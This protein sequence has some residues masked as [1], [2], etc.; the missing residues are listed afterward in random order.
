[1]TLYFIVMLLL[2]MIY[3]ELLVVMTMNMRRFT[4]TCVTNQSDHLRSVETAICED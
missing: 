4:K 3:M 1:M 2:M